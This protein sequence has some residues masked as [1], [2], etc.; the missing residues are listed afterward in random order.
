[1]AR[2]LRRPR[3][4]APDRGL[5]RAAPRRHRPG[6]RR[7]PDHDRRRPGVRP[8]GRGPRRRG[9]RAGAAVPDAAA[10]A[11]PGRAPIRRS[12]RCWRS[13]PTSGSRTCSE[14]SPSSPTPA[15]PRSPT[16]TGRSPSSSTGAA[17]TATSGSS[18]TGRCGSTGSPFETRT[19]PSAGS[20]SST[21]TSARTGLAETWLTVVLA[22]RHRDD[23][24][25]LRPPAAGP[26]ARHRRSRGLPDRRRLHARPRLLRGVPRR[27]DA[28]PPSCSAWP[29]PAASTPPPT[30]SSTASSSTRS[31][32]TSSTRAT[33]PPRSPAART[34]SVEATLHEYGIRPR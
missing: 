8:A 21:S 32:A 15:G 12:P 29:A 14:R 13:H 33:T 27:A 3:S 30:T 24:R 28:S 1:M 25:R 31:C 11:R 5:G 4:R 34:H 20:A 10:P 22:R 23:R 26:R 18:S 2:R 16:S 17:P 9:R 7:L 6:R 19:G